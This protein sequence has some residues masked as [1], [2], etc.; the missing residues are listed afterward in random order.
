MVSHRHI[1]NYNAVRWIFAPGTMHFRPRYNTFWPYGLFTLLQFCSHPLPK[2][3]WNPDEKLN[4]GDIFKECFENFISTLKLITV[5]LITQH[6]NT[7]LEYFCLWFSNA[8]SVY[9][10]SVTTL[11]T[12]S[13]G[14]WRT[15][16]CYL[17]VK[18]LQTETGHQWPKSCY[19][20][21]IYPL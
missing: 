21:V 20:M 8:Q 4:C 1:H 15:V 12:N 5:F 2:S 13:Q 19:F 9:H 14:D 18:I 10:A 3:V 16:H 7:D 11:T 6:F 17:H